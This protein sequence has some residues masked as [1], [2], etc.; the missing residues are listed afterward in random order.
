MLDRV[1]VGCGPRPLPGYIN[2]DIVDYPEC[3]APGIE[4][5]QVTAGEGL[6]F[7]DGTL[8]EVR[9]D[10]FLEHLT[11]PELA[12]FVDDCA[13]MLCVGGEVRF[14]FANIAAIAALAATG[15]LDVV[16][17]REGCGC[18]GVPRGLAVLNHARHG[19]GHRTILTTALVEQL[20]AQRLHVTWHAIVGTN[21][22]VIAVKS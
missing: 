14:S 5:R 16:A 9:A 13:R 19:S 7:G 1:N 11:L 12:A 6:P 4:F 22:L 21:G 10:Q 20:V 8:A 17:D 2:V 18:A 3:H 15:E